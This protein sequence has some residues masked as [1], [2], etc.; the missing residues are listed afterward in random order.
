MA[1]CKFFPYPLRLHRF[2]R[3]LSVENLTVKGTVTGPVLPIS[4]M[5]SFKPNVR[6]I[7]SA[8]IMV[9]VQL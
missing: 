4:P 6:A 8:K 2:T 3:L 1:Q 5:S 7:L 9:D